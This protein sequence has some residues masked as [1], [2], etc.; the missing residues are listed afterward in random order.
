MT[1]ER[2]QRMKAI[3]YSALEREAAD[4][5]AY[6][7]GA[8][9]DD[10][11]L[12][13]EVERLIAAHEREG[14]FLD[15]P[16]YEVAAHMLA[17]EPAASLVGRLISHYRVVELLGSGGMGDVYLAR[18]ERLGRRVA[19]K[20]LP[21][22]LTGDASRVR[23]FRQEARAAS[24]L[25]HPNILT[26]YEIDQTGGRYFIAT[27]YVEGVTLRR[28]LKDGPLPPGEAL[29][30]AAQLAAALSKAH[31]AGIVHRDVKPEN[32]MV[33]GEGHV[34][35]L[36]FGLAKYNPGS[37]PADADAPT[38]DVAHT[39]PG[40]LM[41]TT[42]YMSPEQARGLAVDART[43]IWS[44]GVVLYEM[45]TGRQPF[46]GQTASDVLVAVLDREPD[47][48]DAR[49]VAA[50]AELGRVL[51]KV[52]QKEP[53]RRHQ[54][55]KDLALDLENLRGR[56]PA[57]HAG[58]AAGAVPPGGP[59]ASSSS[60]EVDTVPAAPRAAGGRRR[61]A[62]VWTAAAL[63]VLAAAGVVGV[64]LWRK[65]SPDVPATA[66]AAPAARTERR[67]S[68]WLTMQKYRGGKA[69][70]A[71]FRLAGETV[72]EK[73]DR[74]RLNFLSPQD[75]HLYVLNEGPARD[76][77]APTL[78]ILFPSPTANG[79]RS[80]LAAGRE[81]QVPEQSWF[82]FDDAAGTEKVWLVW[83]ASSIPVLESAGRFANPRDRGVITDTAL[84]GEAREF[85]RRHQDPRPTAETDEAKKEV[86]VKADGDIL[87]HLLGL[88]HY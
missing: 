42:A 67:I 28:R 83:S 44:L 79:G 38:S 31:Q 12:R 61:G 75:G 60:A 17:D 76:G 69:Y 1:P 54:T 70:K 86:V 45:T 68:Y 87:A 72:F 36:D 25:N 34:K 8:V 43:D 3:F 18:D 81:L 22:Y 30:I 35:L 59:G 15:A 62:F 26:V 39:A 46:A 41:G 65:A 14:S 57:A 32:V 21:E 47:F 80:L 37:G 58:R 24:A 33:N 23:R 56:Q 4:R 27:E 52:L 78:T 11:A 2:Y 10:A 6:L 19:L 55:V 50:P 16:A 77:A 40:M 82:R 20:L 48:L 63:L 74:V 64:T 85:L 49:L 84:G 53:E 73:D 7:D 13:A 5:P 88:E 71:P 51:R 66:S 9:G 29:D